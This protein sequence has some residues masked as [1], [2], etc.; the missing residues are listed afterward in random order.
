M[1][2]LFQ[3]LYTVEDDD[4]RDIN[5]GIHRRI[6]LLDDMICGAYKIE[7]YIIE[8]ILLGAKMYALKA[9]DLDL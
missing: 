3:L 5:T 2:E 1:N 4:P 6:K 8:G 7:K 9:F